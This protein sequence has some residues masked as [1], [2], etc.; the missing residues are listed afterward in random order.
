MVGQSMFVDVIHST[1]GLYIQTQS[2]HTQS[3][4][5]AQYKLLFKEEKKITPNSGKF[6]LNTLPQK[7]HNYAQVD[8]Y[9]TCY[10]NIKI[11]C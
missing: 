10:A 3:V 6:C 5:Q 7:H 4:L 9:L 1:H 8:F 11:S 2:L